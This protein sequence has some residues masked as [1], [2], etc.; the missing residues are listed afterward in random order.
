MPTPRISI[1][2]AMAR[3]GV[4]GANNALPWHL[5][6][7]LKRFRALTMGHH[8]VMGRR[9]FESIGRVL[10]GRISVVVTRNPEFRHAGVLTAPS[11]SEAI[12]RSSD[13]TEIFIIGGAAIFRDALPVA[14]RIH[15]TELALDYEGD[16]FFPAFD[17]TQWRET[18]AEPFSEGELRGR[19]VT[20]D[21]KST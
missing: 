4:I 1:I 7:D 11:L 2:V 14:T 6:A 10:P 5:S 20:Y 21:R 17:R 19:F 12:E 3:N 18:S 13:D 16:T 15:A 9:T 8:I